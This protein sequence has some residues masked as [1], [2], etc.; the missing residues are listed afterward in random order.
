MTI[1]TLIRNG[2]VH[3]GE[4][5]IDAK[6]VLVK[7]DK[8]LE[9][10]YLPEVQADLV[11]DASGMIVC[12]GFI[13][14]QNM[15]DQVNSLDHNEAA[16]LVSQG[17]TSCVVGN[18]G[19][20][21]NFTSHR[22]LL[23]QID[24]L[25]DA[26]L[27]LNVGFLVGHNSL[28]RFVLASP[29]R[30]AL[31]SEVTEMVMLLEE[32]LEYGALG[33]SSGLMY[34]PGLFADRNELILLTSAIGKHNKVYTSHIRDEGNE[35][36]AA[37][38][39]ALETSM[40]GNARLVISH[41]KVTGKKHWHKS[42]ESI[43]LVEQRRKTQEAYLDFYPYT[44]TCTVLSII[45]RVQVQQKVGQ[46]LERL[47]YSAEDDA[48]VENF[49]KQNLCAGGWS[50]VVVV[51]SS[52]PRLLGHSIASL[53]ENDSCYRIVVEILKHDPKTIV[54]FHNIASP[55][56]IYDAARL[57]YAMPATDGYIYPIDST[58]ATHPRS[59]GAFS[60]VLHKYV[61]TEGCC[62]LEDFIRKASLL[63]SQVF[64]ISNRGLLR[65]GY[66]ADI[67]VLDPLDVKDMANYE[68]PYLLGTGMRY[69]L[70]NG[71]PV[72]ANGQFTKAFPGRLLS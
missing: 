10:G 65:K 17:V 71:I 40:Y 26:Q 6:E 62:S 60:K 47:T 22:H 33:M 3:S 1:T 7:G 56:A 72:L 53:A 54:A 24:R 23:E 48:L 27:G 63:P 30:V 16:N 12:P 36:V 70:V 61:L 5:F 39:E 8:I 25:R 29:E 55:E 19:R 21:G 43:E 31:P 35:I 51:S 2:I 13:D 59:Y 15:H 64:S 46:N 45:L 68:Q 18:C 49:G 52:E 34:S 4:R 38:H 44:A 66:H 28:R 50:D 37:I 11:I 42:V 69:V 58:E 57:P 9:V 32:A 20:S 41:F 67:I 14:V